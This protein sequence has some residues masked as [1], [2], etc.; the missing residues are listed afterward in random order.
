MQILQNAKAKFKVSGMKPRRTPAKKTVASVTF[1]D[2]KS[3]IG[4]LS[5]LEESVL[6]PV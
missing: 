4:I 3:S 1:I 2:K 6:D 5:E